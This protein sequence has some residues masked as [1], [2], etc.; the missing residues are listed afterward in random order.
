MESPA[1]LARKVKMNQGK[2]KYTSFVSVVCPDNSAQDLT[3]AEDFIYEWLG[4]YIDFMKDYTSEHDDD[5]NSLLTLTFWTD[6]T[7]RDLLEEASSADFLLL[8]IAY[9]V[10]ILFAAGT[11]FRRDFFLFSDPPSSLSLSRFE[12]KC[13]VYV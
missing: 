8:G 4:E 13:D 6:R 10:M 9:V 5:P 1:S 11:A 12:R 2:C 7:K 3:D